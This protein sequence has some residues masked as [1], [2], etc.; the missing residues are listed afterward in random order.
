MI[1]RLDLAYL[2]QILDTRIDS[3]RSDSGVISQIVQA[4]RVASNQAT[5]EKL[6]PTEKRVSIAEYELTSSS[7][8]QNSLTRQ[9][10]RLI[11]EIVQTWTLVSYRVEHGYWRHIERCY[12]HQI[13][14]E[15][16][17]TWLEEI[18]FA[19]AIGNSDIL[20]I[21]NIFFDG[22]FTIDEWTDLFKRRFIAHFLKFKAIFQIK[23]IE[24]DVN[25]K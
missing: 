13:G 7:L 21:D 14:V 9:I 20:I 17:E 12:I 23:Q 2:T 8:G 3:V 19:F 15:G 4:H 18:L 6:K 25:R 16:R 24:F 10:E 1:E 22:H 11:N 5:I